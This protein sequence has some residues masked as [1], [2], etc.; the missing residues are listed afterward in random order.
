MRSAL[1]VARHEFSRLV[2][3]RGFIILTLLPPLLMVALVA[4]IILYE[5]SRGPDEPIGYV[6]PAGA[7]DEALYAQLPNAAD[8]IG[9][10]E[11]A[12]EASGL[13]ALEAGSVQALFVL[14]PEFPAS[15]E[16]TLFYR[17]SPPDGGAWGDF[18][19]FIRLNLLQSYPENVQARLRQGPAVTVLD[20]ESGR[21][22]SEAGIINIFLPFIAG[23]LFFLVTMGLSSNMLQVVADE[24]ENRTME[25]LL[26][27]LNPRQLIGGKILGLLA[28][29]ILQLLIYMVTLTVVL[30]LL[31]PRVPALQAI[32]I[33]GTFVVL[34]VLFFLPTM[35]LIQ[36]VMVAIGSAAPDLQQGQQVSGLLNLAFLAPIMLLPVMMVSPTGPLFTF[37]TFFPTTSFLTISLRW[38]FGSVPQ[39]QIALSWII[40]MGTMLFALW[41]AVR[42]FHSGML[43]YGQP[44]T[45][46]SLV[47]AVRGT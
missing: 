19:A 29:A 6:D 14:S 24:K 25:I 42:V 13:E 32:E 44:L 20:I 28:M 9:V 4:V 31:M 16:S 17:E 10:R 43:Q 39:W 12:D 38:G 11:Y 37:M 41:A 36:A 3:Q 47:A 2:L 23:F 35:I 46:R 5:E 21:T 33:D 26:T 40:L 27:T 45:W 7:L 15:L 8:R 34:I 22:F 18:D 1:L 30:V